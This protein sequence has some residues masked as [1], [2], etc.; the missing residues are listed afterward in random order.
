ML[1]KS[2]SSYDNFSHTRCYIPCRSHPSESESYHEKG[3][4]SMYNPFRSTQRKKILSVSCLA[5]TL[6]WLLDNFLRTIILRISNAT[7]SHQMLCKLQWIMIIN[8]K[9]RFFEAKLSFQQMC[10]PCHW[11]YKLQ[12]CLVIY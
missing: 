4:M 9:R 3:I 12:T 2:H 5:H 8:F 1:L 10:F 6:M 11:N 7:F